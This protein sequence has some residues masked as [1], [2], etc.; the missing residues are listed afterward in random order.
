M[1]VENVVKQRQNGEFGKEVEK[2]FFVTKV[3]DNSQIIA[4]SIKN[5]ISDQSS[6]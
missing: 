5:L 3:C 6:V 2:W 1:D 4:P